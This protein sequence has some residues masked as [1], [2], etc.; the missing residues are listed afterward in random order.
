MR[1][2][3]RSRLEEAEEV[4]ALRALLTRRDVLKLG[5]VAALGL[6]VGDPLLAACSPANSA[7]STSTSKTPLDTLVVTVEGDIDSVD[8]A[9]TVGSKPA[10][11][12]RKSTR[13]NS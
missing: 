12:D 11:T 13:L 4:Q 1:H 2:R 6:G 10:Q 8:P 3:E 7:Q 5:A 9:F